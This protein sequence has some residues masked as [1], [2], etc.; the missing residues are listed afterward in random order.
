MLNLLTSATAVQLTTLAV[1][2][3]L[4]TKVLWLEN[5]DGKWY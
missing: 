3:H 2:R 4:L 1:C 5:N